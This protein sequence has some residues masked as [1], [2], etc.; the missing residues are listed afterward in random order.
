MVV[1]LSRQCLSR[2]IPDQ[3]SLRNE[4]QEWEKE[5]NQRKV[6]TDWQFKVED[7]RIKLKS[8]YPKFKICI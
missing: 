5:R 3:E 2:R 7:A 4:I 1:V 8:L 6:I